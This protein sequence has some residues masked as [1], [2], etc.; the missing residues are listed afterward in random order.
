MIKAAGTYTV[1]YLKVDYYEASLAYHAFFAFLESNCL[2]PGEF[3]Y[4]EA[5]FDKLSVDDETNYVTR[6]SF[7][8]VS[9]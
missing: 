8:I 1:C 7:P 5:I 9:F 6:I 2:T 4:K 3:C